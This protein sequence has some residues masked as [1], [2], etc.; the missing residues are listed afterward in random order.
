[1]EIDFAARVSTF[2]WQIK[3]EEARGVSLLAHLVL[4]SLPTQRAH[5]CH[6]GSIHVHLSTGH[7]SATGLTLI[8]AVL[9]GLGAYIHPNGENVTDQAF[10]GD[11]VYNSWGLRLPWPSVCGLPCPYRKSNASYLTTI[12]PHQPCDCTACRMEPRSV[13]II[14][15]SMLVELDL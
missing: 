7:L 5:F 2:A 12:I 15:C 11:T 14:A 8:R 4:P 13:Q 9:K 10:E 1:M 6:G 3:Q